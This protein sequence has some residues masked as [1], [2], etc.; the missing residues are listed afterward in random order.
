M[1]LHGNADII[2]LVYCLALSR[3]K[4]VLLLLT[5]TRGSN[6]FRMSKSVRFN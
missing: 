6:D 1:V 4:T 3:E 5:A 2:T